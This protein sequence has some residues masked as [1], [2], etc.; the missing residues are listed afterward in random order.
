MT[1][2]LLLRVVLFFAACTFAVLSEIGVSDD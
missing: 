2:I 1:P